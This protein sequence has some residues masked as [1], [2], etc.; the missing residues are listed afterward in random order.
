MCSYHLSVVCMAFLEHPIDEDF[1]ESAVAETQQLSFAQHTIVIH[2]QLQILRIH[3][4]IF[5]L[6]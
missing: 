2:V 1:G 5:E 4:G 6:K 3:C